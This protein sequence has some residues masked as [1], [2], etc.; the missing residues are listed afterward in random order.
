MRKTSEILQKILE[1]S[2]LQKSKPCKTKTREIFSLIP[3]ISI[4]FQKFSG[5][6]QNIF[7]QIVNFLSP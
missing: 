5:I 4:I 2:E 1:I 7:L 6:K 3:E